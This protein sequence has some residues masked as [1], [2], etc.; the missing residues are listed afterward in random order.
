[1][2]QLSLSAKQHTANVVCRAL[3]IEGD[4]DEKIH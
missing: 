3:E 1:M 2:A 4:K